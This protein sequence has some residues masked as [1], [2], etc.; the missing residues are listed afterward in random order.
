MIFR[1]RQHFRPVFPA[2]HD[3][4]F[5]SFQAAGG[6]GKLERD[7]IVD[8]RHLVGQEIRQ[9]QLPPPADRCRSPRRTAARRGAGRPGPRLAS[10]GPSVFTPSVSTTTAAGLAPRIWSRMP[11][12]APPNRVA[13]PRGFQ[14]PISSTM[15]STSSRRPAAG[16]VEIFDPELVVLGNAAQQR[17][18]AAAG[19]ARRSSP[20]RDQSAFRPCRW[21][22]IARPWQRGSAAVVVNG[23]HA[24]RIVQQHHGIRQ[25]GSRERGATPGR[26]IRRVASSP[27][28]RLCGLYS[29]PP[30]SHGYSR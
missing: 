6:H 28:P 1:S 19:A 3:R 7:E 8:H 12:M 24:Q 15:P 2:Q 20:Q 18:V 16:P 11:P 29:G 26:Q 13:S 17:G 21:P 9:L 23:R 14:V 22:S 4:Q 25:A 10:V 27:R 5:S 30:S